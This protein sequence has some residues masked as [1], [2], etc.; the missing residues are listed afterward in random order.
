MDVHVENRRRMRFLKTAEPVTPSSSTSRSPIVRPFM[1]CTR[2]QSPESHLASENQTNDAIAYAS[3]LVQP[4]R[5]H[6]PAD[7][8]PCELVVILLVSVVK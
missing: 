2:K 7:L 3:S 5:L 6:K 4:P 1:K 8:L